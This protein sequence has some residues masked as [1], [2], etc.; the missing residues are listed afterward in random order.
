MGDLSSFIELFAAIYL[1]ISLD[2]MLLKLFWTPDYKQQMEAAFSLINLPD[3]AKKR[4][5]DRASS[6][7]S[8]EES[9]SRKRGV[10][11]FSLCVLLLAIIGLEAVIPVLQT[12]ALYVGI[13]I[14]VALYLMAFS[15]DD[16]FLKSGWRVILVD[17]CAPVFSVGAVLILYF[18]NPFSVFSPDSNNTEGIRTWELITKVVVVVFL[19]LPVIWQLFRNWLY[20]RFYLLYIVEETSIKSK[21]YNYAIHFDPKRGDKMTMVAKSYQNFVAENIVQ[22]EQDR[23][24]TPFMNMLMGEIDQLEFM[25]GIAPLIRHSFMMHRKY[26]PSKCRLK[27]LSGSYDSQMKK[28]TLDEFCQINNVDAKVLKEYRNSRLN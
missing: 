12:D 28:N 1:T 16:L 26:Y 20:T 2:D 6:I 8:T 10:V 7:S 25:P 14:M 4:S 17:V 24:I 13:L 9:R 18:C 11:M 21:E 3:I 27:R 5:F 23:Q 22:G 15:F 19:I